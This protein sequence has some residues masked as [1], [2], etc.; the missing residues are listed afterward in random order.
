MTH[1]LWALDVGLRGT[2]HD[3]GNI[4]RYLGKAT[5]LADSIG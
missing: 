4:S 2:S 5:R 3:L 1:P